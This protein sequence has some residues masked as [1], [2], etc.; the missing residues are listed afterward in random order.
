MSVAAG[1]RNGAVTGQQLAHQAAETATEARHV[2]EGLGPAAIDA[3]G[4]IAA[5]ELLAG[6]LA[7]DGVPAITVRSPTDR[8]T[9]PPH[10]RAT[11][12]AIAVEALTNAVR[13]AH[14]THVTVELTATHIVVAD[15]GVGLPEEPKH[16]LGLASMRR[17][18]GDLRIASDATGTRIEA[19]FPG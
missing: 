8:P 10:T 15:D 18:A 7:P 9:L 1:R 13:H 5:I 12:Y 11:A 14:A 17:R 3:K 19:R 2:L 6:R 4:L 16:G